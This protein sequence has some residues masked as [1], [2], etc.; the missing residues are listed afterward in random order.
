MAPLRKHTPQPQGPPIPIQNP[1]QALSQT[2]SILGELPPWSQ[3][4]SSLRNLLEQDAQRLAHAASPILVHGHPRSATTL[5]PGTPS[6]YIWT[7]DQNQLLFNIVLE[8]AESDLAHGKLRDAAELAAMGASIIPVR[9]QP[10]ATTL[11]EDD[12][13]GEILNKVKL[14]ASQFAGLLQGKI[15]KI[16][17]NKF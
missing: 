8:K 11:D 3:A 9:A 5:V 16:F 10:T 1:D 12:Y 13:T 15:A 6:P 17:A 4:P 14:L 7:L 2:S